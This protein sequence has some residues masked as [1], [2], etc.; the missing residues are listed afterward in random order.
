MTRDRSD[1]KATTD[2]APVDLRPLDPARDG[3]RWQARID[4][5]VARAVAA[6]SARALSPRTTTLSVL[7]ALAP[8][9][10]AAA[11]VLVATAA[12]LARSPKPEAGMANDPVSVFLVPGSGA[13]GTSALALLAMRR[14]P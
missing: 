9:A 5:A 10:A 6:R 1:P 14:E 3:A 7:S 4:D 2:E 12:L 13:R 11:V 8:V